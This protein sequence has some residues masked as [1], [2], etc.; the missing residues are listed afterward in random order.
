[1]YKKSA[2]LMHGPPKENKLR[3]AR[4]DEIH[5]YTTGTTVYIYIADKKVITRYSRIDVLKVRLST[6]SEKVLRRYSAALRWWA[7]CAC[8]RVESVNDYQ[9]YSL[10][11]TLQP[12][13]LRE[14]RL[15]IL[16]YIVP[17]IQ[18]HAIILSINK[19]PYNV[20]L[21]SFW[22]HDIWELHRVVFIKI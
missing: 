5:I 20:V 6:S 14:G 8:A 17:L 12:G 1:M 7:R 2:H 3:I 16:Y 4:T 13:V 9:G 11:V 21:E 18:R 19:Q 22:G 10:L 15:E